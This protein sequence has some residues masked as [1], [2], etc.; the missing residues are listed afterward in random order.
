M[1]LTVLSL[2]AIFEQPLG[3]FQVTLVM[4]SP[5]FNSPSHRIVANSRYRCS[6]KYRS[7][8]L[9][10][11]PSKSVPSELLSISSG[12]P[13][14]DRFH[15]FKDIRYARMW[16][17]RRVPEAQQNSA[18]QLDRKFLLS[19]QVFLVF[20]SRKYHSPGWQLD[21]TNFFTE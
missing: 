11:K 8:G 9:S 15:C 3:I 2:P 6:F 14:F 20:I 7:F 12:P 13:G 5:I 18:T 1:D 19:I 10:A 4:R 16:I 17:E 21:R